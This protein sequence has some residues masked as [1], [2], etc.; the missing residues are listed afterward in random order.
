MPE[1]EEE[2]KNTQFASDPRTR[3][4]QFHSP[5]GSILSENTYSL[6]R[7]LYH[8][9]L[10]CIM[11]MIGQP[12]SCT[13]GWI[14]IWFGHF[15]NNS[16]PM[17]KL[18][19]NVALQSMDFMY[20]FFQL[21]SWFGGLCFFQ[22]VFLWARK[23]LFLHLINSWHNFDRFK[24]PIESHISIVTNETSSHICTTSK[25]LTFETSTLLA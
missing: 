23:T 10:Q 16:N 24:A 25:F 21:Y 8:P 14:F 6:I 22:S 19:L 5:R 4:R 3:M 15:S 13:C 12:Y 7:S 9:N 1:E 11:I 2:G 18:I 20:V 17:Q